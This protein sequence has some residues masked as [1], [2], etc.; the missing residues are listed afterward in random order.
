MK[1]NSRLLSSHHYHNFFGIE[2]YRS[3]GEEPQDGAVFR[4]SNHIVYQEITLCC[5]C[6]LLLEHDRRQSYVHT[7][8][9][10]FAF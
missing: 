3:R 8:L 5:K 6:G 7:R 1:K 4:S 2:W 10:S 9:R